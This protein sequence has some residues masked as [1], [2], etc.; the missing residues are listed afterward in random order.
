MVN[1]SIITIAGRIACF[2]IVVLAFGKQILSKMVNFCQHLQTVSELIT[3]YI[4]LQG[5]APTKTFGPESQRVLA[6][7]VHASASGTR[8]VAT[9]AGGS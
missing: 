1:L 3:S 6:K 8:E 7:L 9:F 4:L 2:V 5:N